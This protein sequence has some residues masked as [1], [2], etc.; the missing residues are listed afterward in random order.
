MPELRLFQVDVFSKILFAGNPAA[1]CPLETWLPDDLMQKIAME[2][3]LSETAFFTPTPTGFHLRWF[4]PTQEVELCGHATLAA[5]HV[6]FHCLGYSQPTIHF[7]TL[8]GI[9]TVSKNAHLLEMDFP[10]Q[11]PIPCEAPKA[12]LEAFQM[13]SGI[14]LQAMD[15][16]LVLDSEHQVLTA[17]PNM[18]KLRMLDRRGVAIT[19]KSER[20]DFVCRFFAP[21]FGIPEDPVTGSLQTQLAPYWSAVLGK[22]KMLG[23]QISQRG[24]EFHL[25]LTG[26]RVLISGEAR[27]YLD[28]KIFI[29]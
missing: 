13:Q 19:S 8:S 1:V 20:C 10:R 28:G 5:A 7:T 24:G 4:T 23:K 12:L 9:L 14:C 25:K 27:L 26:D 11:D 29:P 21:K 18:D 17:Q 2:N 6:L 16:I 3:N 15:Y 22:S